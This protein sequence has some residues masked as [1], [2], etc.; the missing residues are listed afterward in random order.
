MVR[1]SE[2]NLGQRALDWI[3][4]AGAALLFALVTIASFSPVGPV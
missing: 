1:F 4:I 3:A 2:D